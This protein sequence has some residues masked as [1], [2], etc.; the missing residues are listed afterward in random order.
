MEHKGRHLMSKTSKHGN[1]VYDS[2]LRHSKELVKHL[3]QNERLHAAAFGKKDVKEAEFHSTGSY[4]NHPFHSTLAKHGYE[5]ETSHDQDPRGRVHTYFH[6]KY[7]HVISIGSTGGKAAW[8]SEQSNGNSAATLSKHIKDVNSLSSE[9]A[10]KWRITRPKKKVAENEISAGMTRHLPTVKPKRVV[11]GG[12]LVGEEIADFSSKSNPKGYFHQEIR[13]GGSVVKI[14]AAKSTGPFD[15]R[16]YTE[17]GNKA[18][19]THSS[20]T[21]LRSAY[22]WAQKHLGASTFED[23]KKKLTK[24]DDIDTAG[25]PDVVPDFDMAERQK[26]VP[27]IGM[28]DRLYTEDGGIEDEDLNRKIVPSD[29]AVSGRLYTI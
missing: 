27:D 5:H 10:K 8:G 25:V 18:T 12:G 2:A 16:L 9:D 13:H 24:E 15:V 11:S 28:D 21:T 1:K 19:D 3:D 17:K 4:T 20:L 23:L 7:Q 22:G 14:T 29:T 6:P 26:L